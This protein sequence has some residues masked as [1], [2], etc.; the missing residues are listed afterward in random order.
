[1]VVFVWEGA[2]GKD[3]LGEPSSHSLVE[4]LGISGSESIEP[5]LYLDPIRTSQSLILGR[6]HSRRS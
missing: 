4:L 1:M 5:C 3:A 6:N 2:F